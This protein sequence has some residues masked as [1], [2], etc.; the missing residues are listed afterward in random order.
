[1]AI[2][3]AAMGPENE[4][5]ALFR[6]QS[7][8]LD[9]LRRAFYIAA[10]A[11][12]RIVGQFQSTIYIRPRPCLNQH[13]NVGEG[14]PVQRIQGGKDMRHSRIF[15]AIVVA[16]VAVVGLGILN[17]DSS[18]PSV[19]AQVAAPSPEALKAAP[20]TVRR[21]EAIVRLPVGA[22]VKEIDG[23]EWGSGRL[24][25][26]FE[27]DRVTGLIQGSV[28]K[29]D[30]EAATDA[31]ISLSSSG[32]I[33]GLLTGFR[34]NRLRFPKEGEFADLAKYEGLWQLLEPLINDVAIDCPFSYQ[35]RLRDDRLTITNFRM[36][37]AGP[38][39][40]GKLGGLL[41]KDENLQFL[42]YCQ[43]LS[44]A[45]EGTYLAGNSK[46]KPFTPKAVRSSKP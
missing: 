22:F 39:P 25:W 20:T 11:I 4:G 28:M 7:K 35:F 2:S 3:T 29:V 44:T 31:E 45:M 36:L 38:N 42:S 41:A 10:N 5:V 17:T 12:G 43:I 13:S 14:E 15:V 23:A 16:I 24:T 27:D 46:E 19:T 26:T 34:I 9:K 37:A 1:L 32:T 6:R 40:L 8:R 33:Y 30:F 21:Q 18:R